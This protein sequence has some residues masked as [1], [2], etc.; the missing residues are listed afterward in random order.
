MDEKL[1]KLFDLDKLEQP[2]ETD[3][4]INERTVTLVFDKL[5]DLHK[6]Q[7]SGYI[8]NAL[9]NYGTNQYQTYGDDLENPLVHGLTVNVLHFANNVNV[10]VD[11]ED[12]D[13][14]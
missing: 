9:N 6:M 12:D 13:D 5:P 4:S 8:I 14:G 1:H 11:Y 2:E 7:I 3:E 10:R